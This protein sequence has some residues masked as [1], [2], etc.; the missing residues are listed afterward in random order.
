ML[1][2]SQPHSTKNTWCRCKDHRLREPFGVQG[3][4]RIDSKDDSMRL[5]WFNSECISQN[6]FQGKHSTWL[7]QCVANRR[8]C[9]PVYYTYGLHTNTREKTCT[10]LKLVVTTDLTSGM[11]SKKHQSTRPLSPPRVS[12]MC[13]RNESCMCNRNK[14]ISWPRHLKCNI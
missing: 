7:T 6:V 10:Y 11:F 14:W 8:C 12:S 2:V 5:R 3:D 1:S 4:L 13:N 9:F